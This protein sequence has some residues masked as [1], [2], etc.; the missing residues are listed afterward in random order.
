MKNYHYLPF[1]A[2]ILCVILVYSLLAQNA[3]A[4]VN[5]YWVALNANP[6][7]NT[8]AKGFVGFKFSDDFKD[9]IF[10][11][12]VHDID[13]VTGVYLYLKNDTTAKAPILDLLKKHMESNR[14]KDRWSNVTEEG[15]ITGTINL[16]GATKRH[17]IGALKGDSMEDI[18]KLMKDD[19]LY[20]LVYTKYHPKGELRGDQFIGMDDVFNGA[21]QFNW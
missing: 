5:R 4:Q 1:F 21:D 6:P 17:L 8:D 13:N 11:V 16:S 2:G 10:T 19:T 20:I 7:V 3:Y 18:H 14:E 12:N 15:Q 9:I